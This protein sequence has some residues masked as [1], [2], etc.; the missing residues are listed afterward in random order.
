MDLHINEWRRHYGWPTHRW[1]DDGGYIP[2]YSPASAIWT[3]EHWTPPDNQRAEDSRFNS[4]IEFLEAVHR[5]PVVVRG[6]QYR[7][8]NYIGDHD[9][10]SNYDAYGVDYLGFGCR[11]GEQV[12]RLIKEGCP[13]ALSKA[14]ELSQFQELVPIDQK[15]RLTRADL[16]DSLDIAAVYSGH[17]MTAWSKARRRHIIAPQHVDF[18]VQL[19]TPWTEPAEW[20][21]WKGAAAVAMSDMLEM[22]GYVTRI[23]V[24]RGGPAS[25]KGPFNAV[26]H[27]STRIIAKDYGQP[28]DPST[29]GAVLVPG[30]TRALIG[31]WDRLLCP[32]FM[33]K[34]CFYAG[35]A[36]VD[37]GEYEVN[38]NIHDKE[39]ALAWMA[40]TLTKIN[41]QHLD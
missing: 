18:V 22:S 37:E 24:A 34:E 15:R 35:R 30:F 1:E 40:E 21:F 4:V 6:N 10:Q 3:F 23:V 31:A 39:T 36:I 13:K 14:M 20:M 2:P 9:I 5:H 41:S 38:M 19:C 8:Q 11:T 17:H 25:D 26:Y 27:T 29:T 7:Y 33:P 32:F 12:E 28:I 16:G